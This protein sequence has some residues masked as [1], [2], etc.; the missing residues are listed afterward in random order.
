MRS[1]L[2]NLPPPADR[3]E[4]NDDAKMRSVVPL[5][6]AADNCLTRPLF[7]RTL[8][9]CGYRAIPGGESR[10]VYEISV[11]RFS[12]R[13]VGGDGGR[14]DD[15]AARGPVA[16][17]HGSRPGESARDEDVVGRAG[18]AGHLDL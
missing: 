3:D 4:P 9:G 8:C 11:A 18:S 2:R 10:R 12:R 14:P 13:S 16:A 6:I 15:R 1:A 17:C 5:T 7:E